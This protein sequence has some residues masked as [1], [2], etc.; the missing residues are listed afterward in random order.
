MSGK[1]FKFFFFLMCMFS[2]TL[3]ANDNVSLKEI[4][5]N[6]VDYVH[7]DT[8]FTKEDAHELNRVISI[9][10]PYFKIPEAALSTSSDTIIVL[11]HPDE[12]QE[13]F[14]IKTDSTYLSFT[15]WPDD[16]YGKP[17]LS[18]MNGI[19]LADTEISLL[20]KWDIG[21]YKFYHWYANRSIMHDWY[22][23]TY[24]S[25]IIIQDKWR[26]D[27]IVVDYPGFKNIP[28]EELIRERDKYIEEHG[29]KPW[30]K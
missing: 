1:I 2:E 6:Y 29:C 25:R 24:L 17:F 7:Q 22:G 8:I 26:F 18:M 12:G 9:G 30:D 23:P 10:I 3:Y 15:V 21:L 19:R 14:Y 16:G 11:F 28:E 5:T 27:T 20:K 4:I 13:C